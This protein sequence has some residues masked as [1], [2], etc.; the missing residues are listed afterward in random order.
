MSAVLSPSSLIQRLAAIVGAAH[1][2]TDPQEIDPALHDWRGFYNGKAVAVVR[3]AD[4]AQVAAVLRLC[5]ETRTPVVPQGGNT[6]MCGAATPTAVGDA[7]V[8]SLARMNRILALD[9]LNNTVTVEAGCILANLQQAA[10]EADRYFPLSLGAEGSCQIGGNLGTNAGGINVLRYGNTRDLAL[11]L[12]VVLPDGRVWGGLRGLRKDNTGYDL[13]QL[14]I[15]SEGTLG[16][17]TGAVLKVFPKPRTSAT[18]FGAVPSPEAVIALLAHLRGELGERISA[19]EIISRHC[20][21][22]VLKHIP[23]T[24]DPLPAVSPWYFLTNI[25]DPGEDSGL[26]DALEQ[27]LAGAI[28]KGLVTDVALAESAAQAQAFWR[29]RETIPEASKSDGLLYRHDISVPISGI[30][31][32]ITDAG[33]SLERQFPGVRIIC[34]GHI[35]DGNLHYNCFVPGRR[36]DDPAA[37]AM[38]DVN[39]A[40]Y[41]MVRERNGSISAEHG[42]GQAKQAELPHYKSAVEMELMRAVKKTFDPLGIMNP[43]KVL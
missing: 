33:A 28:D 12:E 9:T 22:L 18:A 37:V 41:K 31:S 23:G 30:P 19:F 25:D 36:R 15:G 11:G 5:T 42:I 10:S 43:G 27:A 35:G 20:I 40:V 38:T 24:R 26:R 8:L 1:V 17:I 21:E 39:E 34:F 6:G 7:I 13:K 32:F 2:V 4:T 16:V 14:F 29:I 3:P